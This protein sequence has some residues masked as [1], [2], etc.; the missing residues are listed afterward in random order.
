M[1]CFDK[2]LKDK[3]YKI[4]YVFKVQKVNETIEEQVSNNPKISFWDH[5]RRFSFNGEKSR[6]KFIN[7]G[8][9][10]TPKVN[11]ICISQLGE[12]S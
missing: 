4:R 6:D 1:A 9:T 12:Q 5:N 7:D 8:A 11:T 10:R 3:L 2:R